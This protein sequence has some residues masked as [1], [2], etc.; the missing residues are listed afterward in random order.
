MLNN[1]ALFFTREACEGA[2]RVQLQRKSTDRAR[3]QISV[4]EHKP[5]NRDRQSEGQ[6]TAVSLVRS[7]LGVA[8]L[9]LRSAESSLGSAGTPLGV[10][11]TLLRVVGRL[12]RSA[13]SMLGLAGTPLGIARSTLGLAKWI[14]SVK[15]STLGATK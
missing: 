8:G 10:A 1:A 12:L 7:R 15:R 14:L 6:E 3:G 2:I 5:D 11:G 4:R 9:M 13:G